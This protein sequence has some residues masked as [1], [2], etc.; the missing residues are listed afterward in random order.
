MHNYLQPTCH[1]HYSCC[2]LSLNIMKQSRIL[3][4]QHPQDHKLPDYQ[5]YH[6]IKQY[7]YWPNLLQVIFFIIAPTLKMHN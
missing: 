2:Y 3:L 1:L 5:I 6:I 7:L 4:I